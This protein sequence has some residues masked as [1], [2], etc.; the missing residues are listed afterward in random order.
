M[1]IKSKLLG[2]MAISVLSIALN[3]YI[4]S[5]MLDK[6]EALNKTKS[7]I[8]KI[9]S[10][11]K[12]LTKDSVDFLEYKDKKYEQN[13]QTNYN[14]LTKLISEFS[15][16]L[17]KLDIETK[18]IDKIAKS[19]KTYKLGFQDVISIQKV[20]GYTPKD[21]LNKSLSNA[22]KKAGKYAKRLQDQDIYSMV[23]TLQ[24]IEKSFLITHNK[25]YL[26]KFNRSYNALIYYI[27]EEI[28]NKGNIKKDLAL[29]KKY[30]IEVINATEKK[31]FTSEQGL[32]GK[33]NKEIDKSEQLLSE[34]LN[35]YTPLLETEISKLH[36]FSLTVQ[37]LLGSL[38]VIMLLLANRSIV[39][40]I[41]QLILAAQALTE[42]D[43]DLT[44]RLDTSSK[45]EIAEANHHIN[46]FIEKV[47]NILKDVIEISAQNADISQVLESTAN[48]VGNR[49]EEQ[50]SDLN[51]VVQD[52][53]TMREDLSSAIK[54]AEQGKENL[55]QSERNL[56]ET[57]KDILGLV[58]KVQ[59]SSEVQVA[60][61]QTLSN[62]SN[63]AAQVKD[64]LVVISDIADQTNLLAL[65]AAIEA[66]RA[67]E[68]GR[69]FAVVADEVRKLAERTQKSLTE[70]NATI[71]VILQA[72]VDSSNQMNL[73]SAETEELSAISMQVGDKIN[74]TAS[75]MNDSTRMSENILDGY[76]VNAQKTDTIIDKI[77]HI[78]TISNKN[79][80]STQEV[81]NASVHL[82]QMTE[83]LSK[84][85]QEFKV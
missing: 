81:T 66:A 57:K 44:K 63:D 52:S 55:V 23:L 5:F 18:S 54:E 4:V 70:I 20:L 84:R 8:Y 68:H 22:V 77:N 64:V 40:P 61:A 62:L 69:G 73:N 6:S 42:G 14:E 79:I 30:F 76:R 47:Q 60:L 80:Q 45:D 1:T 17:N 21:G 38:I 58:E 16:S 37:L 56:Q 19:I 67:G 39:S 72:I 29:Y 78:S 50:N 10:Q 82:H 71:N 41:K 43:G 9:D 32:L 11:M 3:I 85:L 53:N 59:N 51:S 7:F 27:D 48:K 46:N 49:S 75:I 28:E 13:F 12:S 74:E 36:T 83:E 31:G 35:E 2:I 34:M 26:K 33:M 25:K 24:N 65:N 15:H